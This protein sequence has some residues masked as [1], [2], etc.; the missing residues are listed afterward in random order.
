MALQL[1][2]LLRKES[3]LRLPPLPLLPL[4]E[5]LLLPLLLT[6]QIRHFP[7]ISAEGRHRGSIALLPL[8]RLL[9]WQLRHPPLISA[10]GQRRGSIALLL[11]LQTQR[12]LLHLLFISRAG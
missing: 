4:R 8:P 6:W 9:T 10:E 12:R 2:Q 7:L 5:D 3:L 1:M 11:L